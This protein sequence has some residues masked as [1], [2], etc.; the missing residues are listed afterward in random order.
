MLKTERLQSNSGDIISKFKYEIISSFYSLHFLLLSP[1]FIGLSR[2]MYTHSHFPFRD[3]FLEQNTNFNLNY[4][5]QSLSY[6]S[7]LPR[8]ILA[9]D[10]EGITFFFL[11]SPAL[12]LTIHTI[13]CLTIGQSPLLT[14]TQ[15]GFPS[16]TTN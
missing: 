16:V 8:L 14:I 13:H 11:L 5:P 15:L 1:S 3:E 9:S 4:S 2:T 12:K 10:Q 7:T 6:D